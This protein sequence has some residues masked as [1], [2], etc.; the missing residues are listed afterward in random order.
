[1]QAQLFVGIPLACLLTAA[2]ITDIRCRLIYDWM[3][4]PGLVYFLGAHAALRD[5]PM[6]EP[7][8]GCLG[9]GALSLMIAVLSRGN[10][11]GG[12]IKLFATLGAALGWTVGIWVFMLTFLLAALAAWPI[13]AFRKFA[14]GTAKLA[15]ELPMAPFIAA[16][17]A[18]LLALIEY[19]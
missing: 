15:S 3:T 16:S 10:F 18:L 17:T 9:L 8:L 13:L 4:V 11:G 19:V 5:L 7:L 2:M 6:R 1:M 12:D 14:S